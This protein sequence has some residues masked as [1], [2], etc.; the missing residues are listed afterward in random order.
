M[1]RGSGAVVGVAMLLAVGLFVSW[2]PQVSAACDKSYP[3]CICANALDGSTCTPGSLV[4]IK[5]V[6][7]F[8]YLEKDDESGHASA[9]FQF[10][11]AT[12]DPSKVSSVPFT[13]DLEST[14]EVNFR[15]ADMAYTHAN[16]TVASSVKVFQAFTYEG[17]ASDTEVAFTLV[18]HQ[19]TPDEERIQGTLGFNEP[20]ETGGD[21]PT[22]DMTLTEVAVVSGFLGFIVG[23]IIAA[24]VVLVSRRG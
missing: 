20:H 17:D 6:K 13:I 8:A 4:T 22:G 12:E 15:D 1:V 21:D 14:E 19:G 9:V 24:V 10:A 5:N 11:W 2:A 3:P 16:D 7:F 23:A 18:A